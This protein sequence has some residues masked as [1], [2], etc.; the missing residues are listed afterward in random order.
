V[1]TDQV[2]ILIDPTL[3]QANRPQKPSFLHSYNT[4]WSNIFVYVFRIRDVWTVISSKQKQ[5]SGA[6]GQTFTI[7]YDGHLLMHR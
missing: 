2:K 1:Q 7:L 6:F 3:K 4:I 5:S